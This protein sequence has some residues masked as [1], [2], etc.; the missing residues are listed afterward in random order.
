MAV[1]SAG[2]LSGRMVTGEVDNFAPMSGQM[3][4]PPHRPASGGLYVSLTSNGPLAVTIES[5]R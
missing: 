2:D 4:L 1:M 5:G 3:Y